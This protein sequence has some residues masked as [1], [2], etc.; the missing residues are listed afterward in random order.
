MILQFLSA[1]FAGISAVFWF[2]SA[3]TA[4]PRLSVPFGGVFKDD[5]PWVLANQKVAKRNRWAALF[6]GFSAATA[7][8]S[9]FSAF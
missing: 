8:A 3:A 5:H 9:G 1:L 7:F 6:A 4:M 2:W